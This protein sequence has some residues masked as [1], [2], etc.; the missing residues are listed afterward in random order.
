MT[1]S[2]PVRALTPPACDLR[3]VLEVPARAAEVTGVR[4]AVC[5]LGGRAGLDDARLADLALAVGEAC[6]N[7]V[8]HAYEKGE[9]GVLRVTAEV[10]AEGLQVVVADEG[11]GMAPRADS[12][13]LGLGLPLMAALSTSLE[14]R[15]GPRGGTETWMVFATGS[16]AATAAWAQAS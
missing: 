6:A 9:Q 7:A 8:V 5:R 10:T 11:R 1:A 15:T 3:V 14:F 4:Q 12:P 16:H 2:A 13:G